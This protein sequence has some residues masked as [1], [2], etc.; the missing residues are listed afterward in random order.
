MT[1]DVEALRREEFPWAAEGETIFLNHASTGPFPARTARVMAEWTRLRENPHR[2]SHDFQFGALE[3]SRESIA[4]LIGADASEIALATNTTYGLNL[5]AFSLPLERGDV[6]LSPDLEFP[7]NVYPWMALA[8][9]RGVEYRRLECDDG[10]LDPDRLRRELDADDRVRAVTVSWVQFASGARVDLTALGKLCRDRGVYFVVDAIQG[11]GP[12]T[13]NLAET[14]VDILACGAQKWLLSPW[15]SGFVYVRRELVSRLEPHEVSWM[16]V[17]GADDF[18][19]LVDYDLSWRD[20]ARKFEFVTVPFQD[21]AAMNASL[22][23]FHELGPAAV[24]RHVRHLADRI[25]D[26]ATQRSDVELV[27]PSDA[28]RRAGIISVRPRDACAASERLTNANVAHSLREGGI[29]LSP[30]CYNTVEEIDRA[31]GIIA[32]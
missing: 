5:A 13:L 24:S 7:A 8:E 31:L 3:K 17:R 20:N 11:L 28:S 26:W 32:K 12:L 29:R 15:G 10:V 18:S 23:L 1:Y 14:P 16:A 6:V 30:H 9:R 25:V 21:L 4:R 19:R 27:T 2:I 22:E